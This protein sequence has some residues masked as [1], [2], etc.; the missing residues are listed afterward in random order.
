MLL[1]FKLKIDIQSAYS[2]YNKNITQFTTIDKHS[3]DISGKHLSI[4]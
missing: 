1:H 3:I 2:D 4:Q